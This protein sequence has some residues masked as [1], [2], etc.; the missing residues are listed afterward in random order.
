M[1][2]LSCISRSKV[3]MVAITSSSTRDSSS[4]LRMD[5]Y[6]NYWTGYYNCS[7]RSGFQDHPLPLHLP[8]HCSDFHHQSFLSSFKKQAGKREP[9]NHRNPHLCHHLMKLN[10]PKIVWLLKHN[11]IF[12][13]KTTTISNFNSQTLVPST[14]NSSVHGFI[15]GVKNIFRKYGCLQNLNWALHDNEDTQ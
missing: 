15:W 8:H 13:G 10:L 11:N 2:S 5:K 9:S 1:N 6:Y 3:N 4:W 12:T 14:L 7:P